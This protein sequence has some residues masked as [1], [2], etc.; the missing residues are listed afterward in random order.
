MVPASQD[1]DLCFSLSNRLSL[2]LAEVRS[3]ES[4]QN[5]L[6][7]LFLQSMRKNMSVRVCVYRILKFVPFSKAITEP[8][9][10]YK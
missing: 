10:Y 1:P 7:L 3:S 8:F 2:G 4:L 6:C 5:E 9:R